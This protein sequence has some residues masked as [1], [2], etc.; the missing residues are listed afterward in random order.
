MLQ[1]FD[2]LSLGI[3]HIMQTDVFINTFLTEQHFIN[4][5]HFYQQIYA[6]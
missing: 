4:I 2:S 3:P 6:N 1:Y 5:L